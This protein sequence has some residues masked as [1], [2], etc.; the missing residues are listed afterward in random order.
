MSVGGTRRDIF[1]LIWQKIFSKSV[2]PIDLSENIHCVLAYGQAKTYFSSMHS[3]D[4]SDDSDTINIFVKNYNV[5]T[6]DKKSTSLHHRFDV[7][8]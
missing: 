7:W 5:N 1:H 2:S 6:I 8:W 3:W 4:A